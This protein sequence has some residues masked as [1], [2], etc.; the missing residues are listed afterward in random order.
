[1]A[2][3]SPAVE[4][5]GGNI[6]L[7]IDELD[8][9][10]SQLEEERNAHAEEVASLQQQLNK[11]EE[12]GDLQTEQRL[13]LDEEKAR[14]EGEVAALQQQLDNQRR[15]SESCVNDLKQKLENLERSH[16]EFEAEMEKQRREMHV[17]LSS[18]Y[19]K[20]KEFQEKAGIL[21][22]QI[23]DLQETQKGAD[24]KTG[25]GVSKEVVT[26]ESSHPGL[27]IE[28]L[29]LSLEKLETEY[30]QISQLNE[31]LQ[32]DKTRMC[33]AEQR[34]H[35]EIVDLQEQLSAIEKELNDQSEVYTNEIRRLKEDL[36]KEKET[37]A[38][39]AAI[40][41]EEMHSSLMKQ[42]DE[43]AQNYELN[44]ETL[45]QE[46]KASEHRE[47][48][49]QDKL[50]DSGIQYEKLLSKNADLTQS[51]AKW[52]EH[53]IELEHSQSLYLSD[54]AQLKA[55]VQRYQTDLSLLQDKEIQHSEMIS[56]L[57]KE[58]EQRA[59]FEEETD[60][61]P[62]GPVQSPNRS[63]YKSDSEAQGKLIAQMKSRLEE[64]Q[65]L[66]LKSSQSDSSEVPNAELNL[67]QELLANNV[68]LDSAAKQMRR[69][70][71]AKNQQLS[72]FLMKRDSEFKRLQSEMDR[73]QK[74]MEALANSNMH[75]LIGRMDTFHGNSNK[76]L[77]K[78]RARIEAAAAMLESIRKSV[79]DQDQRHDSALESALSDLDQTQSEIST[80]KDEIEKLKVQVAQSHHY[81]ASSE[82]RMA[83]ETSR[84][85]GGSKRRVDEG[86]GQLIDSSSELDDAQYRQSLLQQKDSELKTLKDEL[87]NIKRKEKHT[88]AMIDELEQDLIERKSELLSK[89][90]E[91]QQK[92]TLIKELEDK[93]N[94]VE[95]ESAKGVAQF[96]EKQPLEASVEVDERLEV[97]NNVHN[98][99]TM[100]TMIST[101]RC[102]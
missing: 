6:S 7:L 55:D 35:A 21:E 93:L 30:A 71:D 69:K 44:L 48:S 94:T 39:R 1:M 53:A 32:D 28:D 23:R 11:L 16:S 17:E 29:N 95:G 62:A 88:K 74:A 46:L 82:L 14:A 33:A 84:S 66:L 96:M 9:S 92:E 72:D 52:Q 13:K 24:D 65:K 86:S 98:S 100:Y 101:G 97:T 34:M 41:L 70:F 102:Q 56:R 83:R 68:A 79:H 73:D 87:E 31:Q 57:Q 75:Q 42:M 51:E 50:T 25:I 91:L 89:A 80:Y 47:K 58:L 78:Y 76:S 5:F 36:D 15:S 22:C 81:D 99:I 67:V 59:S 45:K 2:K 60:Y 64:L 85:P 90:A 61:I 12:Y 10:K 4:S 40:D 18:A 54:I 8:R 3:P 63:P 38:E 77:D 43:S 27:S 26:V 19:D 20:V 37:N 49:L